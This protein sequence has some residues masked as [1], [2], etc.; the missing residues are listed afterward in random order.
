MIKSGLSAYSSSVR[1]H[2]AEVD[3]DS[4]VGEVFSSRVVAEHFGDTSIVAVYSDPVRLW[5]S[6]ACVSS[7]D[8]PYYFITLVTKGRGEIH[9]NGR[10]CVISPTQFTFGDMSRPHATSFPRP[11]TRLV[12]CIP[13]SELHLRQSD[14]DE[15]LGRQIEA[16]NGF[17]LITAKYF[18]NLFAERSFLDRCDREAA[19]ETGMELVNILL[20]RRISITEPTLPA[21]PRIAI[22]LANVKAFI[23]RN[24]RNP[25]LTPALIAKRNGISIRHLHRLFEPTGD[26]VAY[27]IRHQRID[28]CYTDLTDARLRH[29]TISEIALSWGFNDSSHFSRV[30]VEQFNITARELRRKLEPIDGSRL[31]LNG[32]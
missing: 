20:S 17:G 15:C 27:W 4:A 30:F 2:L 14:I 25:D 16:T 29:V 5:R 6:E 24:L 26:S 10:R 13:R 7:D 11:S 12:I 3:I 23:G 28:R 32:E 31:K 9:H 19:M 21:R 8:R 18:A 22:M 1:S